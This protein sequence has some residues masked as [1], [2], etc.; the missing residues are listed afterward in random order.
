MPDLWLLPKVGLFISQWRKSHDRGHWLHPLLTDWL[1]WIFDSPFYCF[2]WCFTTVDTFSVYDVA[3]SVWL[4]NSGHT[5]VAFETKLSCVWLFG[6]FTVWQ[7]CIFCNKACKAT[8]Q[9][10]ESQSIQWIYMLSIIHRHLVLLSFELP[11]SKVNLGRFQTLPLPR[12]SCPNTLVREF[13]HCDVFVLC[14]LG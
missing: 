9:W 2:Q 7:C 12:P 1:H 4:T 13:G 5:I 8:Q 3:V 11:S 10:A 14:Q 6:S